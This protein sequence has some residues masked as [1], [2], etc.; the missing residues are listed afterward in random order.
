[1]S[2]LK[3]GSKG[4]IVIG[5]NVIWGGTIILKTVPLTLQSSFRI[6]LI[7]CGLFN[8]LSE[9]LPVDNKHFFNIFNCEGC[10]QSRHVCQFCSEDL[11][12]C[13]LKL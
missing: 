11:K 2:H 12:A 13:I 10:L 5:L 7:H 1:M 3:G 9:F 6:M 4:G 8:S